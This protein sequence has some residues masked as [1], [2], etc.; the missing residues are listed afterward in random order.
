MFPIFQQTNEILPG[1]PDPSFP[2]LGS[3]SGSNKW[4]WEGHTEDGGA[5]ASEGSIKTEQQTP[6]EPPP[7]PPL[8]LLRNK[9]RNFFFKPEVLR[10]WCPDWQLQHHLG[11][12]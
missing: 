11:T 7:L 12:C 4:L 3:Y 5:A 1:L 6:S 10:M 9:E 8:R 2:L